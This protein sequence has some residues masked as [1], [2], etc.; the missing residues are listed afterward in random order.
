MIGDKCPRA[1]AT[2]GGVAQ[3]E[4]TLMDAP[5]ATADTRKLHKTATPGVFR[6]DGGSHVVIT[7]VNGKQRKRTAG[8]YEAARRLKRTI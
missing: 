2:A 5:K 8:T 7:R 1:A 3:E 4:R 6:R